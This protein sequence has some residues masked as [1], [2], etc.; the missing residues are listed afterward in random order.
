MSSVRVREAIQED[1][2]SIWVWWNDP[3]T[4]QMMKKNDPVP[5]D[6]HCAWFD[7]VLQDP[8]RVL[9][10]GYLDNEKIGNVRFDKQADR[11]YEVSINLNPD[12]RGRGYGAILLKE[13]ICYLQANRCVELLFA[14]LKKINIPSKKRLRKRVLCLWK[15]QNTPMKGCK[16]LNLKLNFFVN[17]L[18]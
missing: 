15:T 8:N 16:S 1:G 17:Y 14:M 3:V 4:R 2:R 12:F 11:V 9:C 5:W 13:A 6:M 7:G 18:W 10:V